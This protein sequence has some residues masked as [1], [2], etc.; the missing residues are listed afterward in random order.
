MKKSSKNFPLFKIHVSKNKSIKNINKVFNSGFINE[1]M[2][3]KHLSLQLSKILGSKNL[4]LTN[5]GTSALMIAYKLAG[6][7]KG[8]NVVSTPMTCIA[9]N[10]PILNLGGNIKWADIDPNSG[11]ITKESIRKVVDK[12]TVA[13]SIVNWGGVIPEIEKIYKFCKSNKILLI[14]DAA[15]SFM[16]EFKKKP[17]CDFADFTCYSFQAI[18]H[19]T[20][21]DGGA[22]ISKNNNHFRRS[23]KLKW[24]GYDRE[25]SK[26]KAGNW[27]IPQEELDILEQDIGYKFNMNNISAAIGLAGI[28]DIKKIISKHILNAKRYN[29]HFKNLDMIKPIKIVKNSKNVY[30][31]FTILLDKSINR[32]DLIKKLNKFQISSGQMHMANDLYTCFKRFKKNLPGVREFSKKQINLPCGWWLNT[33]DIDFIANKVKEIIY[34]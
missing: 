9:T 10:T 34:K 8:K 27:K 31:V 6:V 21:G 29:Y 14:Q 3:V 22:L 20:C 33:S 11:M 23:K 7:K 12:N 4:T 2:E 28:K 30:W 25:G 16:A 5:S 15:Q 32:N 19:F 26:D 17:I 13:V 18:K 24:F 1:G